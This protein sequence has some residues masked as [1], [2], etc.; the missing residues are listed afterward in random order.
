MKVGAAEMA[1]EVRV[2]I[3]ENRMSDS[4]LPE[5]DIDTLSLEEIILS[6]L[7]DGVRIVEMEAPLELLESGHSLGSE[8]YI[9]KET[10]KG[11]MILPRDFLRLR[12]FRMSDWSRPIFEAI[13]ERDAQYSLQCSKWK[14]IYGSPEK[15]VVAIVGRNEGRVLEFY[16]CESDEATVVQ[17]S[18][19]PEPRI[20]DNGLIDLSEACYRAAVYRTAGLVL[21]SL[22]DQLSGTMVEISRSFLQV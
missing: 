12:V 3:D 14:G 17:G 2:V 9:D 4:L 18:Y 16:S 15:P 21:A 19:I 6:K 7:T 8:V 13:S 11:Y 22:G 1:R 20:D 10:G 5:E